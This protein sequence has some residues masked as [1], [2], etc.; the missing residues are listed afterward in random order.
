MEE[1]KIIELLV[2][3]LS[4]ASMKVRNYAISDAYRCDKGLPASEGLAHGNNA[5]KSFEEA[6]KIGKEYLETH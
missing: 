2:Q 1:N 3:E 4:N 6:I 5:V